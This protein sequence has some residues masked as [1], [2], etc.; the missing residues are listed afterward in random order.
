MLKKLLQLVLGH[1]HKTLHL[2]FGTIEVFDTKRI[3]RDNLDA[4]IVA[5]F[6]DARQSLKPHMMPCYS[7]NLMAS[8]I[9]PVAVHFEGDM[10]RDRPLAQSSY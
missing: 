3:D 5:Y 1:L 9:P 10:A 6:K 2:I 8:G 4:T 7:L